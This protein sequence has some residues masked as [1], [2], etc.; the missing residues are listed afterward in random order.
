MVGAAIRSLTKYEVRARV[1]GASSIQVDDVD[2]P[3][4]RLHEA[5]DVRSRV[6]LAR[7]DPVELASL[8]PHD[9]LPD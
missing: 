2:E 4:P 7:D 6:G 9:L 5:P 1:P 3:R 8:E